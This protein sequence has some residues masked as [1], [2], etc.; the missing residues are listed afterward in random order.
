[1]VI[2]SAAI[3][4]RRF[5]RKYAIAD[6]SRLAGADRRV[7]N[8]CRRVGIRL[9]R[10]RGAANKLGESKV[11]MRIGDIRGIKIHIPREAIE[12]VRAPFISR[13]EILGRV[14]CLEIE[15][16][17]TNFALSPRF[18]VGHRGR[19]SPRGKGN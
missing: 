16:D 10:W 4:T 7:G 15:S 18:G 9:R 2:A 5:L 1:M 12:P 11:P 6:S 8:S 14:A 3:R 19:E 13:Q 17:V